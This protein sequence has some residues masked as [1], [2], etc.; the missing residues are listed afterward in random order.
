M[1]GATLA[2]RWL[3]RMVRRC[4]QSGDENHFFLSPWIGHTLLKSIPSY[5]VYDLSKVILAFALPILNSISFGFFTTNLAM[6]VLCRAVP[7]AKNWIASSS[8]LCLT[9]LQVLPIRNR[10][11]SSLER[12][13][14]SATAT[15]PEAVSGATIRVPKANALTKSGMNIFTFVQI[16]GS[17]HNILFTRVEVGGSIGIGVEGG[18]EMLRD[19][20]VIAQGE[21]AQKSHRLRDTILAVRSSIS[22]TFYDGCALYKIRLQTRLAPENSGMNESQR[23]ACVQFALHNISATE[24]FAVFGRDFSECPSDV[25]Q[26]LQQAYHDRHAHDVESALILLFH[27]PPTADYIPLLCELLVADFHNRHEDIIRILQ[28]AADAR[29]VPFLRQAALLKPS[30]DYLNYDDYGGYYRKCFWALAAIG[31]LDAIAVLQDFTTSE[32][33]SISEQACC[34]LSEL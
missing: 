13:R 30:L 12:I 16:E 10:R 29:A 17:A 7:S 4:Q 24:L 9:Q 14:D 6:N 15:S 28:D 33:P 23:E 3:Q 5:L 22:S 26:L 27:F 18:R 1:G 20:R 25:I 8:W 21:I 2:G 32:D 31:T 19:M 34:R 11:R